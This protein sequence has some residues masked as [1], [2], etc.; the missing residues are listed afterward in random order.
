MTAYRTIGDAGPAERLRFTFDGRALTGRKGDTIASALLANGIAIVGRSFKYHRPRGVWGW[1]HEEPNAI[2]DVK[3]GGRTTP[4]LRATVEALREDMEVRSVNTAPNAARDRRR[5]L[6]R[7]HRFL[8]AGFYYKTFLWPDWGRFE[9]RVRAMAG[10][11]RL[12]PDH[13]PEAVHAHVHHHCDVLVI[14][15]GPAGL[16]AARAASGRA[17]LVDDQPV[18]GGTLLHRQAAIDG[19]SGTDWAR[20]TAEAF[21]AAGGLYLSSSTAYGLYDHNLVCIWQRCTDGRDVLWRIRPR[22]IVLATGAIE[23]PLVFPDND[24]PGVMSAEAA[25]VY[26]RRHQVLVGKRIVVATNNDTAYETARALA[27]AGA[28][29]TIADTRQRNPASAAL[30]AEIVAGARLDGV[31]GAGGLTAVTISGRRIEADGLV[32]SGGMTPSVHLFCQARGRLGYDE[33]IAA[34]IP[35]EPVAGMSVVGAA[36]GCF[37]LSSVL[38]G[39]H[40]AGQGSSPPPTATAA[41]ATYGIEPAWPVPRAKGRQWIDYQNDVTLHDIEL[42][43]RE[44]FRSVEHLKRY[45]TLGMATDQGKTSNMNGLA[46]MAAITGRSIPE[47]GTTTWRPP[48]VP[49]PFPVIAG[50]RRGELFNPLRR[51]GLENRHRAAGASFGEYGGWL[52]PAYYGPGSPE[53]AIAREALAARSTA[54]IFDASPLGKIDVMGPQAGQLVDFWS[55][56]TMSTLKPGSI[57]YG[58]S[59]T[60]TGIVHDDGVVLK[61]ADDHFVVSC[62][63]AHAAGVRMRL[64]EWRQD[65]FDAVRVF[66]HDGTSQ[67]TT[68]AVSGPRSK[69][70]VAALEIGVD[71]DDGALAHMRFAAGSFDDAPVRVQRV[72]FTGERSYEISVPA[73]RGDA[74]WQRLVAAGGAFDAVLLGVEALMVLRAEKGYIVAGKDSDGTTMPH[75]LGMRGPLERRRDEF[76][77]KRALFTLEAQRSGRRQLVGLRP[78]EDQRMLPPGSHAVENAGDGRRSIGFVTTSHDSPFLARPVALALIEGGL[79]RIGEAIDIVHLGEWRRAEIAPACAVDPQGERLHG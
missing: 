65:R 42:A 24:R 12:D 66:I 74:L 19:M 39:G 46:A 69:T 3:H 73:S 13:Q 15:A 57:R 14:G 10:L 62:S 68:L 60:E 6:D 20:A 52:R 33:T 78:V 43:A 77:G 31:E 2:V 45:T 37:A 32:V 7:F 30:A 5:H 25:L 49:V 27:A 16:S 48:Y 71:L 59:L 11:G 51:L 54:A 70:L 21:V 47:T 64:E 55:Y 36:A 53:E 17:V 1:S 56:N 34:F 41:D 4:N 38:A 67:W 75:D 79:S 29:V 8:P 61:V 9:P 35:A 63:S 72:S 76:A 50:R 40:A 18:A 26:L 22:R 58:L 28:E 44:N 23:R